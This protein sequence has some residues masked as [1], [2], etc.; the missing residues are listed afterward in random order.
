MAFLVAGVLRAEIW[1]PAF[2]GRQQ[3]TPLQVV[4]LSSCL[5][6]LGRFHCP[7][8]MSTT[9]QTGSYFKLLL[10][11]TAMC[12]SG[13]RCG[14]SFHIG[15]SFLT[16]KFI[17]VLSWLK[18]NLM[19]NDISLIGLRPPRSYFVESPDTHQLRKRLSSWQEIRSV[20]DFYFFSFSFQKSWWQSLQLVVKHVLCDLLA[21]KSVSQ[22][23]IEIRDGIVSLLPLLP[24]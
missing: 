6:I 18:L 15:A 19:D 4:L 16:F 10:N 11:E 5:E 14:D 7:F 21:L 2:P 1:S 17:S 13:C 8:S 22:M 20:I 23:G 9:E 3:W 12:E 24:F